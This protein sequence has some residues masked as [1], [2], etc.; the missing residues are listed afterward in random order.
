[1][2]AAKIV[3]LF[4]IKYHSIFPKGAFYNLQYTICNIQFVVTTHQWNLLKSIANEGKVY[5][6]TGMEFSTKHALYNSAT[7]L[8]SLKS[9]L[10]YELVYKNFDSKGLQY[11]SVYD[12]FFQRWCSER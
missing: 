7:I 5:Q 3:S 11:Y 1:M 9:L 6:P 10:K 12:V 2:K 8:R 4:M